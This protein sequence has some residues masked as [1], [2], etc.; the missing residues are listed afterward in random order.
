MELAQ[1]G[2]RFETDL[3][4]QHPAGFLIGPQRLGTSP[5]PVLGQHELGPG[6]FPQWL[7]GHDGGQFG[8]DPVVPAE[9]EFQI[10]TRL[11]RVEPGLL[12]SVRLG[13]HPG[14][15][16]ERHAPPQPQR[17]PQQR[18]GDEPVTR[19]GFRRGPRCQGAEPKP[20]RG[21]FVQ[22]DEVAGTG[23]V[24]GFVQSHDAER[25]T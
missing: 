4:H 15:V 16:L 6:A 22:A 2:P 1:L 21:L 17:F 3:L 7:F 23:G 10:R 9:L 24:D 11:H 25:T 8:D 14:Q 12:Q 20:V 18:H 13:T 19:S 5:R